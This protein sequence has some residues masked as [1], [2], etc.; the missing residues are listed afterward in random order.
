MSWSC[1]ST[2]SLNLYCDGKTEWPLILNTSST[3][4][5]LWRTQSPASCSPQTPTRFSQKEAVSIW[6]PRGLGKRLKPWFSTKRHCKPW[7][8]QHQSDA[9]QAG[10]GCLHSSGTCREG[11][12]F[13]APAK[14]NYPRSATS[15][16]H[17]LLSQRSETS[18][19]TFRAAKRQL[20]EARFTISF[21]KR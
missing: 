3:S 15:C 1:A 4:R 19:V 21:G 16:A 8:Q 9:L 20:C 7:P 13:L 18:Q 11:F 10:W 12:V 14:S 17:Q 6:A 2:H 5:V